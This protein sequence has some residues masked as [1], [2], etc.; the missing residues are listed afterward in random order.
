[1][2]L[3]PIAPSPH[4]CLF[5]SVW[6][7]GWRGARLAA[8]GD[9]MARPKTTLI[10]H[11]RVWPSADEVVIEDGSILI[12]DRRILRVGRFRARAD[13]TIDAGGAL[14]MPGFVQTHVHLCQ[15]IFRGAAEDLPLLPWLRER[16]WPLE[17]AHDEDSLR[18]SALL[19]CAEMIRGGTTTFLSM[20]TVRG[21]GAVLEA[22][23]ETGLMGVVSPCLMDGTG[24]YP[25]LSVDT[26]EALVECD[27]LR[28]RLR[29]QDDLR[30]AVAP[31]FALSCSARTMRRAAE[32][33]RD[34]GLLLHTHASEQP[35]EVEEVRRIT[36]RTNVDYL[37]SLG[38]TGP[39]VCLAHCVHL[40]ARERA[41]LVGTGTK[42]LHCP[43]ANFKLGSGIAPV[44]EYLA[45][46]VT[47]SLGAD[48]A[49]CNNR[50]DMFSEMR[51]AGLAQSLRLGPGAL[52]AREIVRMA[53]L[54]GARTLGWQ[55]ELGAL[56]PGRRA[57]LILIDL[58]DPHILPG[59]DDAAAVVYAA[60][61]GAVEL[62]MVNGRILCEE[63]RLTTIDPERLK[64]T[65]RIER[66]K[67]LRRARLA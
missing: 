40:T 51:L 19:G 45:A 1:M 34:R 39:D 49:A 52:P 18:A 58:D 10:R 47:V 46:G 64:E 28:H 12:E 31:R 43:S 56:A 53:T 32:Y 55:D 50:L 3:H 63:G 62:V 48:G 11:A 6:R 44:P 35:G 22:V 61:P 42:V 20:E 2:P 23:L 33:A 67:L 17:A 54:G 26:D 5:P 8:R 16:V 4:S 13:L 14:A 38:L 24:G 27:V 41:L 65:V 25:P 21:T 59:G 30:L 36:G 66:K 9:A 57:N 37:H 60:H 7:R 15:T 29:G